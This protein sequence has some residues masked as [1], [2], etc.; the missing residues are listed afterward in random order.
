VLDVA[1]AQ[2]PDQHRHGTPILVR[3]DGAGCTRE[4]LAHIRRLRD[5]AVSCS[6]S[7]GWAITGRERT[8]IGAVPRA[9]LGTGSLVGLSV[10]RG[11]LSQAQWQVL[12]EVLPPV[13]PTGRPPRDRRQVINGIRW[14]IRTGA[15]WRDIPDRYGPWETCYCLFRTWQRDGSW[16]ATRS[17]S[18][19]PA[20]TPRA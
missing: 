8:A 18:C 1:L 12:E 9:C 5:T 4:F 10:A 15:P 17:P 16:A 13:K 19:R 6:F 20:P 11:D 7:V 14:R 2:I 3:A